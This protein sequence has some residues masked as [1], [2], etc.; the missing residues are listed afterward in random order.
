MGVSVNLVAFYSL[1]QEKKT[2]FAAKAKLS[3]PYPPIQ[4]K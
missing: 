1:L 2:H 4:Q 3:L